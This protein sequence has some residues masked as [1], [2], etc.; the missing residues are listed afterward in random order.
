MDVSRGGGVMIGCHSRI[1]SE[2][3]DLSDIASD[4]PNIDFLGCK[5]TLNYFVFYVVI[6]YISPS[7]TSSKTENFLL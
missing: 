1:Y 3:L 5:L 7:I 2:R 4:V 6:V